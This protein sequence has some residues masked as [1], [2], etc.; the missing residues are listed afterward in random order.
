MG[1]KMVET[2][3]VVK[4]AHSKTSFTDQQLTELFTC[5]DDPL[6]FMRNFM[7]V[8]HPKKGAL[9]F[10][11]FDYQ[12]RA[13]KAF[14]EQRFVICMMSRQSGKTTVASAYLL[15]RALFVPDT[16]ILVTANK[17]LQALE[18]M[19]RIRYAYQEL[20][21]HIRA[22]VTEYNKGN[23]TFDNGSRIIARAT[24]PDAGRGLSIT[25]LYMDEFA[26]VPPNKQSEF[27]TSIQPTLSTGGSCIVTSTPKNDE[28][29]FAQI[30]QGAIDNTDEFGNPLAGGAGKNGFFPIEVP[31][32]EH[33]DRDEEWAR[34]FRESLG[35][36]RFRQEFE[37]AFISDDPTLINPL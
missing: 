12:I 10:L 27:F 29:Q 33:P 21:D 25:L 28:D 32:W 14:H 4:R 24:S 9:P 37:N 31:W 30:W 20:P 16:T 7:R 13:T 26:Y 11:P 17:Y 15:W 8:Q 5:T 35:E 3:E 6:F 18:I 34:P 2:T 36:A 22:G 1:L 19:D 23:I